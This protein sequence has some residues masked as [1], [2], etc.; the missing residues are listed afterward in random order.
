MH[1]TH[2]ILMIIP[3][4]I[5]MG[6]N[7]KRNQSVVLMNVFIMSCMGIELFFFCGLQKK[8]DLIILN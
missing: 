6:L 5:R 7:A 2:P 1:L 3:K 8:D 4:Q